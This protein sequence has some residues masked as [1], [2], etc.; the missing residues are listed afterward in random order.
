LNTSP[1]TSGKERD[2]EPEDEFDR[3][4]AECEDEGI[5]HRAARRRV[6]PQGDII[7]EADEMARA[8]PDEVVI[9]ERV[10]KPLDHRPDRDR[11]RVNEGRRRERD[12][13]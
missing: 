10:E 3:H 8:G 13:E 5:D 12:Q 2:A 9:V 6:A 4:C 1:T 11:Q 7:V